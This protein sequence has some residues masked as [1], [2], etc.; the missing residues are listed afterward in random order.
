[1]TLKSSSSV[2]ISVECSLPS[3]K[4]VSAN[5]PRT[6]S[7]AIFTPHSLKFPLHNDYN[8]SRLRYRVHNKFS[9]LYTSDSVELPQEVLF[10]N[11]NKSNLSQ[12]STLFRTVSLK[13]MRQVI[14]LSLEVLIAVS[15]QEIV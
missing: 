1:M 13:Q 7:S 2:L 9:C 6:L 10:H 12:D 11:V 15:T 14:D 5:N 4:A 8:L 3:K